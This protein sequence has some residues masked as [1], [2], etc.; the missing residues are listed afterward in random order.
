MEKM[1]LLPMDRYQSLTEGKQDTP[2]SL[3]NSSKTEADDVKVAKFQEAFVKKETKRKNAQST[4]L[5]DYIKKMKP[6]LEASAR[7][8]ETLIASFPSEQHERV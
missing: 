3:L 8:W 4:D 1:I 6:I 7:E 2:K 5:D